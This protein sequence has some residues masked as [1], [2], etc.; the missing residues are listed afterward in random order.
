[1]TIWARV[2]AGTYATLEAALLAVATSSLS[3]VTSGQIQSTAGNGHS[4]TFFS[5]AD[6]YTAQDFT[7]SISELMDLRETVFSQRTD[8]GESVTDSAIYAEMLARLQ[9][10]TEVQADFTNIRSQSVLLT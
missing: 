1:M 7:E 6:S 2:G 9:P 4:T 5:G 3:A 10:V 8:A